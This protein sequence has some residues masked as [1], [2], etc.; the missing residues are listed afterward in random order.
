MSG[1]DSYCHTAM[2]TLI[3]VQTLLK[4]KDLTP[5]QNETLD[6]VVIKPKRECVKTSRGR[7]LAMGMCWSCHTDSVLCVCVCRL[8]IGNLGRPICVDVATSAAR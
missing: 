4:E 2:H 1:E 3:H 8:G 7:G 6:G 5:M